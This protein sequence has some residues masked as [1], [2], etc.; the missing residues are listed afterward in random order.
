MKNKSNPWESI[1]GAVCMNIFLSLIKEEPKKMDDLVFPLSCCVYLSA[2]WNELNFSKTDSISELQDFISKDILEMKT[3][4]LQHPEKITSQ[5]QI[6]L[7][8]L[9]GS[10]AF[11][12]VILKALYNGNQEIYS[13]NLKTLFQES[14][15]IIFW[16]IQDLKDEPTRNMLFDF[17]DHHIPIF[18]DVIKNINLM[19]P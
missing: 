1:S 9:N 2:H 10:L 12:V 6:Y 14:W 11:S 18:K 13:K 4:L 7:D 15:E 19:N 3:I 5:V 16:F 8:H 17:A